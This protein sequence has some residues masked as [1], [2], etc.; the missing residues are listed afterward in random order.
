VRKDLLGGHASQVR[1]P[2]FGKADKINPKAKVPSSGGF[3]KA[4]AQL[5]IVL[6]LFIAAS[7]FAFAQAQGA[8]PSDPVPAGAALTGIIE[9]GEGVTSHKLYDIKIT[10]LEV[11]RGEQAWKRIQASASPNR[12]ADPGTEYLPARIRYEYFARG[13]PGTCVHPLAPEEFTAYP[14][15]GEDYKAVSVAPPKPELRKGA[16]MIT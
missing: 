11:I 8:S 12:P 15:N 6:T 13:V 5:N 10:L 2:E 1:D 16:G 3:V 4:V 7:P 14:K 9:C